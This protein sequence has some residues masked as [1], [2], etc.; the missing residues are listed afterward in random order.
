M[1]KVSSICL[2]LTLLAA[3]A[4]LAG[5]QQGAPK[6]KP[7]AAQ[8]PAAAASERPLVLTEAIPL[9]GVKGGSIIL[10]PAEASYSF[11]PSATI[12]LR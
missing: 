2:A 8:R 3:F 9:P 1:K 11:P 5:G 10:P 12:P 4:A 6:P 7:S